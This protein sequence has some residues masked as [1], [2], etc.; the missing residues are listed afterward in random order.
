MPFSIG[1]ETGGSLVYPASKAGLYAIR[2]TLGFVSAKGCFRI[3]HSFDGIGGMAKTPSDLALIT[4]AILTPEAKKR[5][6]EGGFAS[7]MKGKESLE[8]MRIG[9]VE[10]LWGT[11]NDLEAKEASHRKWGRDP[12]VGISSLKERWSI[13]LTNSEREI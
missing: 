1:T 11:G 8:G 6:P 3:S 2:P 5:L 10:T 12:V 9:F 13:G 7:V 4:E